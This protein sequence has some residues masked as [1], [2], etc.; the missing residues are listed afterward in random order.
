MTLDELLYQ[1]NRGVDSDKHHLNNRV[2][3]RHEGE[4]LNIK[5]SILWST[6]GTVII[7][8]RKE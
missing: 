7:C 8:L 4:E 1:L 2:V 3:V 5:G 6:N